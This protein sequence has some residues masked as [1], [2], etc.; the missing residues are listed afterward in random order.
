M[1]RARS[2]DSG[3]GLDPDCTRSI[4]SGR[5]GMR[6]AADQM[7]PLVKRTSHR[8]MRELYE[9]FIAYSRAYAE[10]I[11]TYTPQD[12]Y[13]AQVAVTAGNVIG[14]MCA[15]ISYGSASARRPLVSPPATPSEVAPAGDAAEPQRFLPE[16]NPVC[17]NWTTALAQFQGGT[18]AWRDQSPQIFQPAAGRR[19]NGRSM[20]LWRR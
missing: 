12:D 8:V 13:L 9:Q 6:S 1:G 3:L 2:V 19:N 4:R 17:A 20:S 15:A 11:P 7:V 16:P 14:D 10:R 18:A 5:T